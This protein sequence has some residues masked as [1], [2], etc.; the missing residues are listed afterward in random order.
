VI[1]LNP[2]LIIA[3]AIAETPRGAQCRMKSCV[4]LKKLYICFQRVF[5]TNAPFPV[6]F[7]VRRS[8]LHRLYCIMVI[9]TAFVA[10]IT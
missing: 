8:R 10:A 4:L 2:A 9:K 5:T 7:L 6:T 1:G 3:S